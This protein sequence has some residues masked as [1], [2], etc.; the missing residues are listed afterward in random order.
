MEK[1]KYTVYY[2]KGKWV[3]VSNVTNKVIKRFSTHID[4]GKCARKLEKC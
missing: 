2:R 4:A 3:I 1:T